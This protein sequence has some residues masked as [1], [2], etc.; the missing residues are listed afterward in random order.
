MKGVVLQNSCQVGAVN[1]GPWLN[2]LRSLYEFTDLAFNWAFN[3]IHVSYIRE[4]DEVMLSLRGII[5]MSG[6]KN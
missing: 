4:Q 3:Q 2:V 1:R 5:M 6:Q